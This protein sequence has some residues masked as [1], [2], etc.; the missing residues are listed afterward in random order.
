METNQLFVS[1][2]GFR[3]NHTCDHAISELLGEIVKS[4]Q[5]G[6]YTVGI[7]L[8]LSKAF[9]TLQHSVIFSK[10]DKYGIR[11][12]V[13]R[14]FI[15]YLT[16]RTLSVKCSSKDQPDIKSPSY[17]VEYGTP[18]GSCLGPLIFL[19]FCNDIHLNM[20]FLACIQFA[21]DTSLHKS[22]YNLQYLRFCV[23]HDMES[24]Q[25]W[26]RANK[27]TLNVQ[28]S[29]CMLFT[30]TGKHL[31]FELEFE[32]LIMPQVR[33]TKLLGVWVDEQLKW[34]E[35]VNKI[36]LKLKA[37]IHMLCK[38]KTLLSTHAKR[39]L[40][41]A[42][43]QSHLMYGLVCWG[44]MI[45][46]TDLN[47]LRKIQ[48]SCV[49]F[50]DTSKT[51]ERIYCDN[52]I[53]TIDKLIV[54]ENAKLWYKFHKN[55]LPQRLHKNMK[56]DHHQTSLEKQHRYATR[57]KQELNIP[58]AQHKKYRD[59]FLVKGLLDYQSLPTCIKNVDKI[60]TF[61]KSCKELLLKK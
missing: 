51:L 4:Q 24:L 59:S 15:S 54:L 7:F 5:L 49:R 37:K 11:G 6:K 2:Y 8:D 46:S 55:A 36:M 17:N 43:I 18:Q 20:T 13:L 9:D 60:H 1:Q 21:D 33:S 12:H 56:V 45:D 10:L 40:Y 22:H 39:I 32:G 34:H 25:D 27:L 48:N 53:L 58:R 16:N 29:V 31:T 19:I 23:E 30:P 50:I 38:G 57:N 14:W 28:K 3:A 26:F 42:Q 44:N 52:K 61:V 47:R 35:H 41:F